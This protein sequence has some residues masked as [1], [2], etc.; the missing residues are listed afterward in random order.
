MCDF[1]DGI[2][3]FEK[4]FSLQENTTNFFGVHYRRKSALIPEYIM[5]RE[6]VEMF[7]VD[8]FDYSF[9]GNEFGKTGKLFYPLDISVS[10]MKSYGTTMFCAFQFALWTHPKR[11]YIVGADCSS[12][13]HVEGIDYSK[14]QNEVDYSFLIEPWKMSK[15]FS[16]AFYPDV[17]I[18]SINP[19]GLRGIFNDIF[20]GDI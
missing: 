14:A 7:Y 15:E 5:E 11:I 3:Y 8:S 12:G 4:V 18:F 1:D 10:P 17:E 13:G 6:N 20:M 2:K 16:E 9:W 19:V